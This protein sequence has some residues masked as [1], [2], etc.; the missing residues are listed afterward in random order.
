[1][2]FAQ[3]YCNDRKPLRYDPTVSASRRY[4]C[5]IATHMPGSF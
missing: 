4:G 5:Y 1:M 2:N 3:I